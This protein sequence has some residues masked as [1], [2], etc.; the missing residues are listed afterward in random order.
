[1]TNTFEKGPNRICIK[2]EQAAG[3]LVRVGN[4]RKKGGRPRRRGNLERGQG[5]SLR[6]SGGSLFILPFP[7]CLSRGVNLPGIAEKP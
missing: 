5:L 6:Y 7:N 1:M 2:R 4:L 3:S